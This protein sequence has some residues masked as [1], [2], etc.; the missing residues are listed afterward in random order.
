MKRYALISLYDTQD[1]CKYAT[2]LVNKG[3]SIITS[4]ESGDFLKKENIPYIDIN[5]FVGTEKNFIFPPTLHP[6]IEAALTDDSF[7]EKIDLVFSKA[8][9]TGED[10]D[11]VGFA[12][13]A[14]AVKGNR[15]PITSHDEM[16]KVI[17]TV[18]EEE[19]IVEN[20]K[21]HLQEK[22]LMRIIHLYNDILTKLNS[23]IS[24]FGGRKTEDLCHGENPYQA[25]ASLYRALNNDDK[26]CGIWLYKRVAGESP[27]YTNI[28]DLDNL[29]HTLYLTSLA[30]H[31][32]YK[33]VPFIAI[34]GKHGNPCGIAINWNTPEEALQNALWGNP[35]AIWGGEFVSNFAL[36][37]H[38]AE[39]LYKS[40]KR[41]RL[42]GSRGWMLD[43]IAV[44]EIDDQALKILGRRKRRKIYE[45]NNLSYP[46]TMRRSHEF[47]K[48]IAGGF[49]KQ[50]SPDYILDFS[51]L[52]WTMGSVDKTL[53]ASYIVAWAAAYSSFHGGNEVAL[54]KNNSLLAVGGGPSTV[55]AAK[56]AVWRA[57]ENRHNVQNS[58]FAA[59]AFFPFTDAVEVLKNSH[60]IGGI[61]PRG[62]A[63]HRL[64]E[65]FFIDNNLK[66]GFIPEEFRGFCRH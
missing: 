65:K 26:K 56:I 9:P 48:S 30:S 2:A 33:K 6:K 61:V 46:G 4:R 28:A 62:G 23:N 66:V 1:V 20:L 59:D 7:P 25:P 52:S 3:W 8:Y 40:D 55:E 12:L 64:I 18:D 51:R 50:P 15:I 36:S 34:A 38:L 47:L 17:S 43:V 53:V 41:E 45:Q 60:C 37:K 54:A 42:L 63:N 58:V 31:G 22:M 57:R 35:L 39:M 29:L 14:L 32:F 16:L 49:L 44:P 27:C 11:V 10:I 13:L 21:K 19:E 5:D 24:F